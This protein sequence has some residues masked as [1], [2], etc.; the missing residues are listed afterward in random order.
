MSDALITIENCFVSSTRHC[1]T[2][3]TK[4][5]NDI[6]DFF[7]LASSHCPE[8]G[9]VNVP[10]L[11]TSELSFLSVDRNEGSRE[12]AMELSQPGLLVKVEPDASPQ[13]VNQT[14]YEEMLLP[15]LI[16]RVPYPA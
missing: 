11:A 13:K 3:H 8:S 15:A 6:M 16:G 9:S 14:G 5:E 4:F 2:E 7:L 12:A 10:R 1:T